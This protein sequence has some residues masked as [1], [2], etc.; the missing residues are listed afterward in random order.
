MFECR[1]ETVKLLMNGST[2]F[3]KLGGK[4]FII[5]DDAELGFE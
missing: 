5:I 1:A 3:R 2:P 4:I